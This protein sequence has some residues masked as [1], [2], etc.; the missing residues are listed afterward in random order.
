MYKFFIKLFFIVISFLNNQMLLGMID[1]SFQPTTKLYK[2]YSKTCHA[3]KACLVNLP[4]DIFIPLIGFLSNE[5][6]NIFQKVS[7]KARERVSKRIPNFYKLVKYSQFV[8]HEKDYI[9]GFINAVYDKDEPIISMMKNKIQNKI[10]NNK[11]LTVEIP[12]YSNITYPNED[13][14]I[15]FTIHKIQIKKKKEKTENLITCSR[16]SYNHKTKYAETMDLGRPSVLMMACYAG[17]LEKVK[18]LLSDEKFEKGYDILRDAFSIAMHKNDLSCLELF[19]SERNKKNDFIN[20]F[21]DVQ[22]KLLGLAFD[23]NNEEA[24][25][26]LSSSDYEKVDYY[27]FPAKMMINQNV[28]KV[29]EGDHGKLMLSDTHN[30]REYFTKPLLNIYNA[31]RKK[32]GWKTSV[33]IFMEQDKDLDVVIKKPLLEALQS[34]NIACLRQLIGEI[35]NKQLFYDQ[36]CMNR[37][38]AI[39]FEVLKKASSLKS[40]EGF[41]TLSRL[42]LENE[43]RID[44][45]YHEELLRIIKA[46]SQK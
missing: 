44:G 7:K 5:E 15:F 22:F 29:L 19:I 10:S 6:K 23:L 28:I 1:G 41:D 43:G 13:M 17:S 34:N 14:K 21:T 30:Y 25:A 27:L 40:R 42:R 33:E 3:N 39:H 9:Y 11:E 16:Q 12:I 24:F 36:E 32:R 31:E 46:A 18:Q 8:V 37:L 35:E 45:A 2:Q 4:N 38:R 20:I 26:M